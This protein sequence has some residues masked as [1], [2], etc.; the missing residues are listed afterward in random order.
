MSEIKHNKNTNDKTLYDKRYNKKGYYWGKEPSTLAARI[1]EIIKPSSD[2]R[3]NLLDLGCGEG[4]DTVY[5]ALNGFNTTGLDLSAVGLEKARQYALESGADAKFILADVMDYKPGHKYDV[6][7]STG[8]LH[9]IPQESR[10]TY[11]DHYKSHTTSDGINVISVLVDKPF[12]PP[13][14][15]MDSDEDKLFISGELL[16]YYRDWEIIYCEEEI[17]A[18]KSDCSPHKHC[19]A[20]IIAKRYC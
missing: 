14:P 6:I 12:L 7:F 13:A 8:T 17:F 4:R 9:F 5:F 10:Q 11:F 18:C 3:P 15:D 16:N 2:F 1:L 19:I 20:R